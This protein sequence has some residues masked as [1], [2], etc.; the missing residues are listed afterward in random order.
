MLEVTPHQDLAPALQS[1]APLTVE[2]LNLEAAAAY[3]AQWRHLAETCIEPNIFLDPD[4]ALP[5]ARHIAHKKPPRFLFVWETEASGQRKLVGLFPLAHARP[6]GRLFAPRIWTHEQAPLGTPLLD[7]GRAKDALAAVFA[8][9]RTQSKDAGLLFPLLPQEGETARLLR[10]GAAAEDRA[11]DI[12][13]AHQRACLSA[14]PD[15]Q[16]YLEKSVTSNRRRKL[17]RA[18]KLLEARGA[19]TFQIATAPDQIRAAAE[20][21]LDLEA[22]GWKGRRGTAFLKSP[23]RAAFA[24]EIAEKLTIHAKY[25]VASLNL[26]GRPLAVGLILKSGHRAFWWKIAYDE[27]F[28]TYSPGVLLAVELTRVLLTDTTIE[29]TDSCAQ[30]DHPMI[31]HIWSERM[32]IAD[33]LVAVDAEYPK[34]FAAF[35]R[36]ESLRRNLRSHLKAAV[37]GLRQRLRGA[38][39]APN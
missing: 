15:P 13:A 12:F 5:A 33:L 39:H 7:G 14:G 28:A 22:K 17:K 23:E 21:F 31:D 26:N 18:H 34:K 3:V 30:A 9:C 11:I 2:L 35:A 24:S 38:T 29:M 8:Y 25:S 6:A 4:F 37:L 36:R 19:L 20:A 1:N 32:G 10:E 16:H 27:A